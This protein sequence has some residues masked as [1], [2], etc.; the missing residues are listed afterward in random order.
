MV[1]HPLFASAADGNP[2][3]L[4]VSPEQTGIFQSGGLAHAT[5]GLATSLNAEGVP[6]DVLMPYFLEMN[7]PP[8]EW[9]GQNV[10]A[11][12]DWH[13]GQP[14][15]VSEFSVL[16]SIGNG[17][18]TIFLKHESPA[19]TTNYFDNRRYRGGQKFYA[20]EA[21]IG[22][23]FGAFAQAASEYIL[24][25][26]YDIVMLNDW[27][28]GLIAVHLHDAKLLGRKVPKV[29]FAIHNIAYQG[30]FPKSLADFLGLDERHFSMD[31]YEFYG[32][33]NFLKAGLLYSD[34]VYTVSRQYAKEIATPRYGAGLDGVIRLLQARNQIIGIL[35]GIT[36]S[37]WVP[38]IKTPD[39]KWTFSAN[40]LVGK[41]QG[42]A[43][44]QEALGLPV[45][46]DVP[47]F[48]LTSRLAEQKGFAYLIDAIAA[49]AQAGDTQ[50]V[51]I[52]DG[53]QQFI[54]KLRELEWR[55]KDNVRYREFSDKLEK[56]L[57][58]YGDFFVNGAYFEPSGLN[59]LFALINGTIPVVAGVGG[60]EDSVV[61][62]KT[63]L[64]F[65]IIP[66]PNNQHYDPDATR[67]AAIERFENASALFRRDPGRIQQ[68]RREGMAQRNSWGERVQSAFNPLFRGLLEGSGCASLLL[69]PVD[70]RA[71]REVP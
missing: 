14:H 40:N 5:T 69:D 58:R 65:P 71:L 45:R 9:T 3:V 57:T 61:D 36:E 21:T 18:P 56:Q 33:M 42:K 32:K 12:L 29:I 27:T 10:R 23:S 15:K 68:M 51:V 26:N 35:N 66:G 19:S 2:R 34:I 17:N 8:L 1:F 62:E 13:G 24:S 30:L 22:E 60:L 48:V 31:G 4:I 49:V 70:P 52:G 11:F 54:E 55:F 39:L 64:K 38:T 53:E 50:W 7:A 6:T 67:Q 46:P 43:T 20:P 37:E 63:G 16:K 25:Q 28:S 47:T 41:A 44:L 59:Q